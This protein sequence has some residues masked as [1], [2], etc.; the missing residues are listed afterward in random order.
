MKS[1]LCT[2]LLVASLAANAGLAYKISQAPAA[3]S[4]TLAIQK[5]NQTF[6]DLAM[7]F[8]ASDISIL[9]ERAG[10]ANLKVS[11]KAVGKDNALQTGS[12]VFTIDGEKKTVCRIQDFEAF[13]ESKDKGCKR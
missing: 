10:K 7:L 9:K 2:A 5:A 3:G 11:E 13:V 12:I 6:R 8:P 4:D 1:T